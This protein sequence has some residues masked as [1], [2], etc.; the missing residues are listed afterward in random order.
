MGEKKRVKAITLLA[1]L[2]LLAGCAGYQEEA[3]P[4][5][6]FVPIQEVKGVPDWVTKKG[7]MFSGELA[8][9]H[10]VG[11]AAGIGNPA[12]RR[13]AAEQQAR[14][15]LAKSFNVHVREMIET[16]MGSTGAMDRRDERQNI[17]AASR[18]LTDQTLVGTFITEYWEHPDGSQ[19]YALARL[20]PKRF[21]SMLEQ[22]E[23]TDSQFKK[24]DARAK[25]AIEKDAA[26]AQQKMDDL[27]E[28]MN[29]D[30]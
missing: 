24:L 23:T 28:K 21:R 20:D 13:K 7:L 14:L 8:A 3:K 18:E 19:A 22:L 9:F 30:R 27:I 26:K 12:L 6:S 29:R 16:Y 17:E 25:E 5:R 1:A 2:A 10:G 11:T 4:P 15:D